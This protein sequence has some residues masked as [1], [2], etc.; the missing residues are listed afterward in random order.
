MAFHNFSFIFHPVADCKLP[1]QILQMHMGKYLGDKVL[2]NILITIIIIIIL[3]LLKRIRNI[4]ITSCWYSSRTTDEEN[5]SINIVASFLIETM[6]A[7]TL[8]IAD[9]SEHSGQDKSN[10]KA[11]LLILKPGFISKQI[12]V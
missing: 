7:P 3:N 9:V 10:D 12:R 8:M 2:K 6:L 5:M 11:S 1:I 4:W